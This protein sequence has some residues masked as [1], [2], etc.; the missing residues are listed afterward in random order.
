MITILAIAA[1]VLALGMCITAPAKIRMLK[2]WTPDDDPL[3]ILG[4]EDEFAIGTSLEVEVDVAE[5]LVGKRYAEYLDDDE[6]KGKKGPVGK[7]LADPDAK[8]KAIDDKADP[9]GNKALVDA[10]EKFTK[11]FDSA[12]DRP[13]VKVIGENW[14]NQKGFGYSPEDTPK[15]H[16]IGLGLFLQD[17][18]KHGQGERGASVE[19]LCTVQKHLEALYKKAIGSDEYATVEDTIGGYFIQ[20]DFDPTLLTKGIEAERI[21]SAGA[22]VLPVTGSMLKVNAEVDVNRTAGNFLGGVVVQFQAER[23]TL[24]SARG[25]FEQ[26]ELKP[27][28]LTGL[29]YVTDNLLTQ[30]PAL[31]AILGRQFRAGFQRKETFSFL[32]GSGVGVPQGVIG[33]PA[34]IAVARDTSNEINH[35]DIVN[36]MSKQWDKENCIWLAT[37][38]AYSQLANAAKIH[39]IKESTAN[40]G[41]SGQ[42]TWMQNIVGA[43]PS[44]LLGRPLFFT[45]HLPALGTKGDLILTTWS[46]YLIGESQNFINDSSIHVRFEVLETTFRFAKRIDARP[47]WTATLTLENSFVVSAFVSLAA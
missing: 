19:R 36:M 25:K 8:T 38:G 11:A 44:V 26:I 30:V 41:G 37:M 7:V 34:E 5:Q 6:P 9:T 33:C 3:E 12:N 46:Q 27:D 15:G 20:P 40:V 42:L 16:Q 47:W 39:I 24:P 18:I 21:R 14:T 2:A 35:D 43:A 4:K 17:V 10:M 28:F 1:A 13:G 23:T 45:E 32:Q 29:A 31:A 22:M